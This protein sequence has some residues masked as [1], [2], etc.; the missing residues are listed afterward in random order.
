M[1]FLFGAQKRNILM[2]NWSNEI[3]FIVNPRQQKFQAFGSYSNDSDYHS[4]TQRF[5]V[6]HFSIPSLGYTKHQVR[7]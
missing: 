5:P 7:F 3:E 6:P 4:L 1:F 2:S